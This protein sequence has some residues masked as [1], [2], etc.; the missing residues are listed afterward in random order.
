M[1]PSPKAMSEGSNAPHKPQ[2]AARLAARRV[3]SGRGE[4]NQGMPMKRKPAG[5]AGKPRE[6]HKNSVH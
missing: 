1:K 4:A 3:S 6:V 2:C 5:E